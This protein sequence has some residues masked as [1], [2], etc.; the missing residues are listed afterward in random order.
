MCRYPSHTTA[1]PSG[2]APQVT[3]EGTVA[4]RDCL[5][6]A[7]RDRCVRDYAGTVTDTTALRTLAAGI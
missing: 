6:L 1:G 5:A 2:G 3:V 4:L 7:R